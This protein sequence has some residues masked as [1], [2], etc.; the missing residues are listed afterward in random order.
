MEV[1]RL[2]ADKYFEETYK[3]EWS[4][5]V[6]RV[7]AYW[8]DIFDMS[9]VNV[10]TTSP[11][12]SHPKV[13][14]SVKNNGANNDAI[15]DNSILDH[16][17]ILGKRVNSNQLSDNA[18]IIINFIYNGENYIIPAKFFAGME[19]KNL[20]RVTTLMKIKNEGGKET[21][22]I[23]DSKFE[24]TFQKNNG[25]LS[26][27]PD[28]IT[29]LAPEVKTWLAFDKKQS[30]PEDLTRPIQANIVIINDITYNNAS[31]KTREIC[32]FDVTT[33]KNIKIG[34]IKIPSKMEVK[35]KLVCF[36]TFK[37][38]QDQKIWNLTKLDTVKNTLVDRIAS[39]KQL[40]APKTKKTNL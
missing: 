19:S 31:S 10:L 13:G 27:G 28:N 1:I 7:N 37:M 36:N 29:S 18:A 39:L 2:L 20:F 14:D 32:I 40:Y 17:G 35:V 3:K 34:E 23:D 5:K 9:E 30:V 33:K 11:F 22:T 25:Q 26:I 24:N 38:V 21:I 16:E 4:K 15:S 8:D 12:T 6:N